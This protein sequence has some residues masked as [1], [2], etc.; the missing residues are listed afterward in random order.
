[1]SLLPDSG[2]AV[3]SFYAGAYWGPRTEPVE[4]CADRLGRFLSLVAEAHPALRQ[5]YGKGTS[6]KA[7]RKP[8][9]TTHTELVHLLERGRNRRDVGGQPIDELGFSVS[10]WNGGTPTVALGATVGAAPQS[11]GILN[12]CLLD[13]PAPVDEG[14]ELYAPEVAARVFQAIVTCWEPNWASL[15]SSSLRT[16][17]HAPAGSPVIGWLT[18]LTADVPAAGSAPAGLSVRPLGGGTLIS[19]GERVEDTTIEGVQEVRTWIGA[20]RA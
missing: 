1:M 13:F 4:Q 3:E 15:T 9:E 11:A 12:H 8:I 20:V 18:Y 2:V 7:A 6:R 5:W 14:R 16:I 19:L 10:M 17:Q